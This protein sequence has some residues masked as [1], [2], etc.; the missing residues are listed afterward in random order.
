MRQH[1]ERRLEVLARETAPKRLATQKALDDF[2][3]GV[4]P[5]WTCFTEPPAEPGWY[6][7]SCLDN[8]LYPRHIRALWDGKVWIEWV[9]MH[10]SERRGK[11]PQHKPE[12][13]A[14]RFWGRRLPEFTVP[15]VAA[16]EHTEAP[17]QPARPPILPNGTRVRFTKGCREVHIPEEAVGKMGTIFKLN[18][19]YNGTRNSYTVEEDDSGGKTWACGEPHFEVVSLPERAQK[20]TFQVGQIRKVVASL[21][22]LQDCGLTPDYAPGDLAEIVATDSA[23]IIGGR[24]CRLRVKRVHSDDYTLAMPEEFLE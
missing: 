23:A 3:K 10:D 21:E 20:R 17:A 5:G 7:A 9:G 13:L 2:V 18:T 19:G 4:G 14:R 15:S 6:E 22:E 12:A 24:L 11:V 16:S 1:L 8:G